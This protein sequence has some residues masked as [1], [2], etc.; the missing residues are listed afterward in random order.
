MGCS[1]SNSAETNDDGKRPPE[2]QSGAPHGP[3][4]GQRGGPHG[5][6][7][8]SGRPGQQE[9]QDGEQSQPTKYVKDNNYNTIE[10]LVSSLYIIL[11]N[12]IIVF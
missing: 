9:N 10:K 11:L 3:H 4:G 1:G 7:G 5:G 8:R 12:H 2:E 6:M